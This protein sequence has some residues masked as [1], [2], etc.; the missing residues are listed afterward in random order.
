MSAV[1]GGVL[2][3]LSLT[4]LLQ[5][6]LGSLG[7]FD[8]ESKADKPV[9]DLGLFKAFPSSECCMDGFG[10]LALSFPIKDLSETELLFFLCIPDRFSSSS[11]MFT[12]FR[13]EERMFSILAS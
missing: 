2:F 5:S 4:G 1:C 12:G 3:S 10:G 6:G 11:Y 7:V 13:D 9:E 8:L